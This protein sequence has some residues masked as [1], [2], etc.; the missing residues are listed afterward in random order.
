MFYTDLPNEVERKLIMEIHLR[1][2]GVDPATL[3][4]DA[5]DWKEIVKQSEGFV[6]SE[7]EEVVKSAR[8]LALEESVNGGNGMHG[9]PTFDHLSEAIGGTVPM[10]RRD[11]EGMNKIREYCKGKAQPVTTPAKKN[12]DRT[13]SVQVDKA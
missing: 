1:K 13:R 8:Y 12:R 9:N 3:D 7:L 2:R 4:L 5:N 6:G 10:T 11:P